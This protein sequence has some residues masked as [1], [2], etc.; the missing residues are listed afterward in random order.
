MK[1]LDRRHLARTR[2][3][4]M[5]WSK[6]MDMRIGWIQSMMREMEEDTPLMKLL[7]GASK[8]MARARGRMVDAMMHI[9][10]ALDKSE[11]PWTRW[12]RDDLHGD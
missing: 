7:E 8:D 1:P 11:R 4:M 6:T 2:N 12:G 5:V 10:E 9:L 3:D